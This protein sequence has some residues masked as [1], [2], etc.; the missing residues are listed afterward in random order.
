MTI[1]T[2]VAYC[3]SVVAAHFGYMAGS[4]SINISPLQDPIASSF[5]CKIIALNKNIKKVI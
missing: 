5:H 2:G 1:F 3:W 4:F